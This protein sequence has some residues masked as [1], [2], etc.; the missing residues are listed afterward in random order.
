M[1]TA[2][3][4]DATPEPPA[5][6]PLRRWP[7]LLLVILMAAFW[8]APRVA[9]D[10][11]EAVW[12]G[13]IL[14]PALGSVLVL[15]WWLAL[16]RATLRERGAG[17]LGVAALVGLAL[18]AL[19]ASMI[20]PG[21]VFVT[22]PLAGALFAAGALLGDRLL[23][24]RRCALALGLAAL[25]FGG[26]ALL[27]SEGVYGRNLDLRW[28]WQATSEQQF[29]AARQA[30]PAAERPS[31]TPEQIAGWLAAPEWPGFRGADR[32]SR[33]R[34]PALAR[35]WKAAPERLWQIGVGP[36]WSSFAVAGKLLFTQEQR[37]PS[38][39]VVCYDADSG[40][41]LWTHAVES[42]FE[43]KL[44]GPGPRATPQLAGGALYALGANG[45]LLRLDPASGERVWQADIARDSGCAPPEWGFCASPLV[46]GG[47]VIVHAG[48]GKDKGATLG[49]DA[50]SGE[51]A[52]SV[53]AGAHTYAS[54]QPA[55]LG[56]EPVVLM[57]TDS[58]LDVIEPAS[59]AV[60]LAHAW[61]L[62]GYRAVQP[63]QID[64]RALLLPGMGPGT[65][66][67]EVTAEGGWSAK[68]VWRTRRFLP[69]FNDAVIHRD[70]AFG[71]SGAKFCCID[72]AT[73]KR[74]WRG[75]RYGKGQVLLLA[76]SDALLVVS[77]QGEAVLLDADPA[78]HKELGRFQALDGKTWNHPVVVGDR[79]YI[80]NA[81]QAACYRL[82]LAD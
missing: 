40:R 36:G 47:R 14:G 44:G 81:Q 22:I 9:D 15:L 45:H 49:Y 68:Q 52:W 70:H 18:L 19:D 33:Q 4:T 23:P 57:L 66:R 56:G 82:P 75:G 13:A 3:P 29:L 61:K 32:A 21:M 37:G 79:L 17:F 63:Q 74:T 12:I 76:D 1:S 43:D 50:A 80:R 30:A 35:E 38:E 25:A 41:E 55:T 73:G 77:E 11:S 8:L 69:D 26:S 39:V 27:R 31:Y 58:G 62:S 64:E 2:D 51:L 46:A 6:Q 24:A 34:G 28:R 20:G 54:P 67:L 53:P 42:R 16:S 65:M 72:L 78:A 5:L 7:A 48:A 10:P 59:G 71:W 60:R